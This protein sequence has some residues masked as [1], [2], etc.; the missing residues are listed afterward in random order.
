MPALN[1]KIR[2]SKKY[3]PWL[4]LAILLTT[5]ALI[6]HFFVVHPTYILQ[7]RHVR[8]LT[9][10]LVVVLYMP[11]VI[12]LTLVYGS[13]V[14]LCG[15][16]IVFKENLLLTSYSTLVNFFGPLQSGPGVR[17]AYLKGKHQVRIRD[18]TLATLIY[19][20]FFA[21]FSA[22]FLLAGNRPWWQTTLVVV[23]VAT[24]SFAVIRRSA[25]GT[26]HQTGESRFRLHGGL[27]ITLALTTLLQLALTTA[28]YY[29]ELKTVNSHISLGQA[30]SYCGAANFAVFVSLTPAAIGFRETFLTLSQHFHHV[31]TANILGANII[32]RGAY[33]IY[34]LLLF[35]F[36]MAMHVRGQLHIKS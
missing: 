11:M 28:C 22:L 13:L 2:V 26:Q 27:L 30:I 14:K 8:P 10:L 31:S 17:A 25:G 35:V 15:K 9:V 18:Y 1:K 21:S 24:L 20:G 29:V 36:V 32:D 12:I 3:L 33:L 5:I 23:A 16:Q 6:V 4:S 34:L 19:Y 7:L